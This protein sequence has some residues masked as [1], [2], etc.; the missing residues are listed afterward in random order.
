MGCEAPS[1]SVPLMLPHRMGQVL[2]ELT[3]FTVKVEIQ[4][5]SNQSKV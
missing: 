2:L 1:E 3:R 4:R 5:L